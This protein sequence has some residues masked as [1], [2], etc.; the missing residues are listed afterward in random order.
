VSG[1]QAVHFAEIVDQRS[2]QH[3]LLDLAV[4]QLRSL[5]MCELLKYGFFVNELSGAMNG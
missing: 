4:L 3:T 1:I 5:Q 2:D